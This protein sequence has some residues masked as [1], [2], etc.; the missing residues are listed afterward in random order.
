MPNRLKTRG[1]DVINRALDALE[2]ESARADP[3]KVMP[4]VGHQIDPQ[5]LPDLT[6]TKVLI[7]T[8]AGQ[9][10]GKPKWKKLLRTMLAH[11]IKRGSDIDRLKEVSHAMVQGRKEDDGYLYCEEMGISLRPLNANASCRTLVAVAKSL[12]TGLEVAFMWG[13]E[14]GVARPGEIGWFRLGE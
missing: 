10:V 4:T 8:V 11:A 14:E 6:H 5:A 12:G 9:S 2:R 1:K 3:E 13:S 7:A